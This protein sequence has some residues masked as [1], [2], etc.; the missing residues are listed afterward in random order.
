[1][2]KFSVFTAVSLMLSMANPTVIKAA[3]NNPGTLMKDV[4]F[5][6]VIDSRDATL[7]LTE[8]AST[9]IGR[10]STLTKTQRY[11]ADTDYDRQITAVDASHILTSY[12]V[13]SAGNQMPVKTVLF[14]ITVNGQ[15]VNYQTFY[16]ETAENYIERIRAD[17]PADAVFSI[18]ADTTIFHGEEVVKVM[19]T[20]EQK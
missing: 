16:I 11:I 18:M 8:Y 3:E 1:M 15:P 20:V 12:A 5:N 14:G 17:Y 13:M 6:G 4:D 9:S 10:E 7:V 19:Y 2:N